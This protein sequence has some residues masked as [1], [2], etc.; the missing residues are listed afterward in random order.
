MTSDVLVL[1]R[2]DVVIA[3]F[4][5]TDIPFGKPR[6][7]AVLSNAEFNEV[8]GQVIAAMIT[9]GT[10]SRWESDHPILDLAPTGLNHASVI[11]WK[12]MTLSR[13]IIARK[14][15]VLGPADRGL[16]TAK[17]ASILLG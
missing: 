7:V 4:P 14:I 8:H 10:G 17:L 11:R 1:E 3:P 6:P 15:G 12:L 13:Q 2:W 5:F 16:L 9:T